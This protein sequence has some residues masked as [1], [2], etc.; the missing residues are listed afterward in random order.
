MCWFSIVLIGIKFHIKFFKFRVKDKSYNILFNVV[1]FGFQGITFSILILILS[2]NFNSVFADNYINYIFSPDSKP[3]GLSLDDWSVK[4]WQWIMKIAKNQNPTLDESGKNC[5][6]N[7]ENNN[8]WFLAGRSAP[9]KSER[10]C[11]IPS[12]MSIFLPLNNYECNFWENPD[13]KTIDELLSCPSISLG[14]ADSIILKLKIDDKEIDQKELKKYRFAT[15]DFQISIPKDDIFGIKEFGN[16]TASS[17]GYWVM[18]KPLS[19]GKHTISFFGGA[20]GNIQD[21]TIWWNEIT[22]NLVVK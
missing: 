17:D 1:V 2:I 3:Y 21:P 10:N 20:L 9:G 18:I 7:Q 15:S 6:V 4:W 22:Y 12:E 16:T 8:V 19:S 11:E 5:N 13:I 14:P